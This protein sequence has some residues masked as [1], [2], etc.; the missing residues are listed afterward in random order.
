MTRTTLRQKGQITLP[1]EVREALHVEDGDEI[2]FQVTEDGH[3]LMRGLK[4]I[5][6][7]QAWFWTP[8][9][10]AGEREASVQADRGVVTTYQ[11]SDDLLR[12]FED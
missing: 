9:W 7:D 11:N 10:Q 2:E 8:E 6:A 3:V 1:A 12:S 5:P 4:M